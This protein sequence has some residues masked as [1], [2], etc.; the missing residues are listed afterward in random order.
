MLKDN[1]Y[2]ITESE[3]GENIIKATIRLNR[4][5]EIFRGH[6][7]GQPV[8]PGACMVQIIKEVL[9]GTLHLP[10]MLKKAATIKFLKPVTPK[11]KTLLLMLTYNSPDKTSYNVTADLISENNLCFK[12]RGTF[13]V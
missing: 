8:L 7:P 5:H 11:D 2:T 13:N 6:F 12:F 1:L 10:L 4:G 9:E 3:H